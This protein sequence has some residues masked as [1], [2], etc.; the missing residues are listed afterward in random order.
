VRTRSQVA[1]P[2]LALCL[3]ACSDSSGPRS[4]SNRLYGLETIDGHPLPV[5][6]LG[7]A[8]NGTRVVFDTLALN[9]DS[10]T[11]REIVGTQLLS[12]GV[13]PVDKSDTASLLFAVTG[14]SILFLPLVCTAICIGRAGLIDAT[15][16]TL[17]S[18][19]D[20]PP[21]PEYAYRLVSASP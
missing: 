13:D 3:A 1:L 16:I 21:N 19:Y 11:A 15:S 12:S 8:A 9:F 14:D 6:V 10:T 17:K 20:V 18:T 7:D 2:L 4:T 5:I